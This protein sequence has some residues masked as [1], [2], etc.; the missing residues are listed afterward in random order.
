[1]AIKESGPILNAL[2][3]HVTLPPRLPSKDDGDGGATDRALAQRLAKHSHAFRSSGDAQYYHQWSAICRAL[4]HFVTLHSSSGHLT[5][6]TLQKAFI[7]ISNSYSNGIGDILIIHIATQNA[8]L[9]IRKESPDEFIFEAFEASPRA[10]EV[11]ASANALQWDFPSHAVAIPSETFLDPGFQEQTAS[12]LERASIETVKGF[13]ATTAKAGSHAF[14][15]RDTANPALIGQL[16]MALLEA[17]GSARATLITQKRVRDDVCWNDGAKNPWRRSAAWLVL[18]VGLQRSLC[19]LLGVNIGTIHYKFFVSYVIAKLCDDIC[20]VE[21]IKSDYLAH[22]RAK[23]AR[24]LVKLQ[25]RQKTAPLPLVPTIDKM[26]ALF[27]KGFSS[28]LKTVN[29]TLA[30]EWAMIRGRSQKRIPRLP[31]RAE[32]SS[33]VLSLNHSGEHLRQLYQS[34][35]HDP[36][37]WRKSPESQAPYS[38]AWS[39][40]G[41]RPVQQAFSLGYYLNLVEFESEVELRSP[42][43]WPSPLQSTTHE[44]C[45]ELAGRIRQYQQT[46]LSAYSSNPEQLSLMLLTI[47]ELWAALDSMALQLFPLLAEYRTEIPTG[48]LHVLQITRLSDLCRLRVI[49]THLQNRQKS[50]SSA[51]PSVFGDPSE[52]CFAVR[53]FD[54]CNPMQE[55]LASIVSDGDRARERKKQEWGDKTVEYG[56]LLKKAADKTCLYFDLEDA[57]GGIHSVHD[58]RNCEKHHL[59][60]VA[61]RIRIDV[62]EYPL[63]DD[64]N[65]AKAAVFELLCPRGFATWR[66]TTWNI[67]SK[68]GGELQIVGNPP[69]ALLCDYSELRTYG[70]HQCGNISLASRTKSF[71]KT[72]YAKVGFPVPFEKVCLPNGLRL[73]LYDQQQKLWTSRR[74]AIPSFADLC[75]SS[76]AAK[77]SYSSL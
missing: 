72:H 49:E 3:D 56:S 2:I 68:L 75:T 31:T 11:L 50:A 19:L 7:D 55:L 53:Y 47:M 43:V 34:S 6:D 58:E 41:S 22:V 8:G 10:A 44:Q 17:N 70:T 51:L 30:A 25:D 71:L 59:E 12:F 35:S 76:L 18:R 13:A 61:R 46:A 67:I 45:S 73:G 16:L 77:S 60:R 40:N 52:K 27:D 63:P 4:D 32:D 42:K 5:K 65:A 14:E 26:F 37:P 36:E 15:S 69:Q 9:I 54:Q 24:R 57:L 20:D 74:T 66:D 28:S 23:L 21:P 48:I 39:T 29:D 64:Q 33:L 62:H 1:M 38:T